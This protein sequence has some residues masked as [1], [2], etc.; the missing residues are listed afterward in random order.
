[1]P[2]INNMLLGRTFDFSKS[3]VG[4]D[5]ISEAERKK[6]FKVRNDR[7]DIKYKM[8]RS[9]QDVRDV[10]DISGQ[11]SVKVMAGT[12]NVEGKGSYLKS[13]VD[14]E[15]SLEVMVQVYYKT[16]CFCFV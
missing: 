11:L 12:V 6:A 13:S 5:I 2:F 15:S 16:V 7:S 14:S 1:V 10:L 9:S 8:I 3:E 4:N